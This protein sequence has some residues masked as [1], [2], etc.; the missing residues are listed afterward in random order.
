[1]FSHPLNQNEKFKFIDDLSILE[2]LNLLSIGLASYNCYNH[3]PSDVGID[4]LYLDPKNT[5]SQEYLEKISKWTVKNEMKLN[6]KK[7]NYMLFNFSKNYKFNTRLALE[8]EN[9]EQ[10]HVTKLLGL[11]IRDDL[12]WK[13]N[14]SELTRKA[15]SRMLIIKKLV[16]FDVPLDDL[17]HIYALYIRSVT[18]QSAVVWHSAITKGEQNDLERVQKVALRIILGQNYTSYS[19]ALNYT[20]LETLSDRRSN[21]CLNFAKKCIKNEAPSWMFPKNHHIVNTR[22]PEMFE[23]TKAKTE[24]LAKSAIPYM[25]SLLNNYHSRK[26]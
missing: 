9:L 23:V 11:K 25:Q 19:E 15:Y 20:G 22:N 13:S 7:T 14:T 6:T 24:R 2:I 8:G 12:S 10:V 17:L 3:V 21:L 1:M 4:H 26:R 18:E 5:Q 16:Q